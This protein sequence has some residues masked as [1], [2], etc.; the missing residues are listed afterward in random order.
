[1]STKNNIQTVLP[2]VL[3]F[4][5]MLSPSD[6]EMLIDRTRI[7]QF[8]KGEIIHN[9][10]GACLG[11]IGVLKG[12]LCVCMLS[13]EGREITLFP[14]YENDLCVFGSA[15]VLRPGHGGSCIPLHGYHV[16]AAGLPGY[17]L[18]DLRDGFALN[19]P[20]RNGGSDLGAVPSLILYA[21]HN[22]ARQ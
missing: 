20:L 12:N 18:G 15:C 4:W 14:L 1:M 8:K 19:H 2:R 11:L 13:E 22:L 7:Q 16:L 3:P 6:R 5:E 21:V 10:T 17:S 9:C